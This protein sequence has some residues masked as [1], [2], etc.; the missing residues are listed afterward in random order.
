MRV[1]NAWRSVLMIGI[2]LAISLAGSAIVTPQPVSAQPSIDCA[3]IGGNTG[4]MKRP[5]ALASMIE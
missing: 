3:E 4:G 2:L 1:R 5:T